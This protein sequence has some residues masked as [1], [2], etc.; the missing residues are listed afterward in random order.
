MQASAIAI[1]PYSYVRYPKKPHPI[2][3]VK[4]AG[5]ENDES[6]IQS[7]ED[8][9]ALGLSVVLKPQIWVGRGMWTGD[10]EMGSDADW[11]VFFKHYGHWITHYAMLAEIHEW[12]SLCIGTELIATTLK[13][14]QDWKK[15]ARNIRHIYNGAM[16]YAA[17]WG[18]EFEKTT[19]WEDLDY[20]GLN[21]YYP[22]SKKSNPSDR[23]LKKGFEAVI[24][25]IKTV[26]R[27]YKKPVVF[28]EI[29]FPCIEAPWV[30]PHNDW[31][32]FVHNP[33]HQKRCY[34]IVFEKIKDQPW[35]N[36][37]LWWKYPS[38]LSPNRRRETGFTPHNKPA[39]AVVAKWFGE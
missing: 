38:D 26:H 2:P 23:E 7:S 34:E 36:G 10:I 33:Q 20:I 3:V 5:A 24:D 1:V 25:K 32:E 27:R 13:R 29:G 28:T 35:C 12:E 11:Q 8:A 21:C 4:Q 39:E 30:E 15:L 17:N 18:E 37:I 9:Q 19:L 14:E 6:V 31:G 22:L 16:T